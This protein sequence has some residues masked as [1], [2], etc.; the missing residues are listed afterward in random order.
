MEK[1]IKS[2]AVGLIAIILIIGLHYLG[3]LRPV[4]NLLVQTVAPVQSKVFS[5]S[6]G[7]KNFYNAWLAKRDLLSEN[8][9][10]KNQLLNSQLDKTKLNS[11][12]AENDL[13]KQE[14]KFI[15][16]SKVKYI[17]ATI[18]TGVSDSDSQSIVIDRGSNDGLKKGLA[19]VAGGGVLVGKIQEVS[20]NYSK[21][22]LLSDNKSRVAATI[23]NM[24]NTTGLVEGQFGLSFS[25][26]NIPQDQD[27][28]EGDL[29]VTSGL[30]GQI[31]K[32]LL[33]AKVGHVNQV[34]SE[35]FKTALLTPIISFDNLSRVIVIT[36]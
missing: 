8:E 12:Q 23:Q 26:T 33:I 17:P 24:N 9:Q 29:I 4:E 13:L 28:K 18:I 22:L 19:V 15:D 31:P 1:F 30:E 25:M 5:S 35:I 2:I 11:L 16:T 34:A 32:G 20:N 14:L 10:L 21:V 27:L 7:L 36:P 6:F 3:W